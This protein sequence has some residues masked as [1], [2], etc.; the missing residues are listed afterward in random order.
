VSQPSELLSYLRFIAFGAGPGQHLDVRWGRPD[1]PMR[2]RLIPAGELGYAAKLIAVHAHWCDVYV[3]VALRG[4][5]RHGGR[6]AV[7]ASRLLHLESDHPDAQRTLQDFAALPSLVIESGTPGHLHA[8]W[9][10]DAPALPEQVEAANR[11]LAQALGGEL[12]CA[13]IARLLRPPET[14]NHK[15][16]P[17][18]PV[19]RV[20]YRPRLRYSLGAVTAALPPAAEPQRLPVRTSPRA[21]GVRAGATPLERE[22]LEVSAADYVGV[23]VETVP[24]RQGKIL[25]PFHEEREASLQLYA[26]GTFYCF[27]ASCRRGGT[28]IDFAGHLWGITPRG[29]GFHE[30]LDR[31]AEA[32]SPR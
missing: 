27:G 20:A 22:L 28:I 23:L 30:I 26:D 13:G 8:Y 2:K 21:R 9:R 18:R 14:L 1:V 29:A 11:R 12:A 3:G 31:L 10:L 6:A 7:S 5:P 15:H 25:C 24:N 19:R 32:L 4:D 16:P 17:P